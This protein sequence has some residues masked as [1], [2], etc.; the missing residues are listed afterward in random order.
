MVKQDFAPILL[1]HKQNQDHVLVLIESNSLLF[2]PS[3]GLKE[4][5]CFQILIISYDPVMQGGSQ[6]H[7][8]SKKGKQKSTFLIFL[9]KPKEQSWWARLPVR[10]TL[11]SHLWAA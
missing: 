6:W 8:H 11:A 10:F 4:V 7:E 1:H 2:F 3:Y 5:L 9:E